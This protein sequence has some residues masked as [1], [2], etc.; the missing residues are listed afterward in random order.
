MA[1]PPFMD[2]G[3][4][5]KAA[6]VKK[7]QDRIRDLEGR[8]EVEPRGTVAIVV[9]GGGE[10]TLLGPLLAFALNDETAELPTLPQQ[11]AQLLWVGLSCASSAP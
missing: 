1:A 7:K 10:H 3:V 8:L 5:A 6:V 2:F 11:A 9:G 4:V